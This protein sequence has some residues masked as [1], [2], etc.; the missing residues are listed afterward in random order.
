MPGARLEVGDAVPEHDRPDRDARVEVAARQRVADRA[1][2]RP[3]PVALELRD[4]LHRTHLRRAADGS[5]REAGAKQVER[6]DAVRER[7]GH[8]RDEMRHVREALRLEEALDLDRPGDADPR[9][10]VPPEVDEHHVLRPVLLRG[11]QAL[12]VTVA[13]TG[14]ARDRVQARPPRPRT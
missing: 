10:V 1:G 11:E 2:I 9:K 4:Q 8:L 12:G 14:R 7:A 6:A 5:G 3:A 13:R